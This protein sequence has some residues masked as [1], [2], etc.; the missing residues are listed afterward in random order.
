MTTDP[1]APASQASDESHGGNSIEKKPKSRVFKLSI[2][3]VTALALAAGYVYYLHRKPYRETDDAFIDGHFSVVSPRVAGYVVAIHVRDNQWVK[4]GDPLIEID[5]SDYK[6]R[7][8]AA[9]ASLES[10][11]ASEKSRNIDVKVTAI[12]ADAGLKEARAGLESSRFAVE[13]AKAQLALA[14]SGLAQAHAEVD[15]AEARNRRDRTDLKRFQEMARTQIVTQ[16]SLEHMEAAETMS[17]A[18]VVA[19]KKNVETRKAMIRQAEAAL[20]AAESNM[21][22]AK[23]RLSSAESAPD[24][25]AQ[26][27]SHADMAAADIKKAE[28]D[29]EQARLNLSYT[30]ITAPIDGFVTRKKIEIGVLV[31]AG[32]S[33]LFLVPRDVWVTANFKETQIAGMSPGQPV[34]IRVD[35]YP[36]LDLKGHVD[37]IQRGTGSL[38]SLLPPENATGNFVKVVQRVPVKIVFDSRDFGKD[39]L[40]TPGMSVI[41]VVN[42]GVQGNVP[43]LD[44][45]GKVA[46]S[47]KGTH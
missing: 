37:S 13:S 16:Q 41:A 24:K 32:Q 4:A 31:Q 9:L 17:A 27:R 6:A 25:V 39:I 29:L 30:K 2:L 10:A 36:D 33:I 42:T 7:L 5:D 20:A 8:D 26:S 12:T 34:D 46:P 47:L 45:T 35:T 19:A 15:S 21:G 18:D 1:H 38:F 14:R 22:Q 28:A 3:F 11:K 43:P 23:A 44:D 40:L